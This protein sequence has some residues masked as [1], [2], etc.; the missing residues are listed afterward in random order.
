MDS[1]A[2]TILG[3]QFEPSYGENERATL[4]NEPKENRDFE[5]PQRI[6]EKNNLSSWCMCNNCRVMPTEEECTC[7][8]GIDEIKY[9]KLQGRC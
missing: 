1:E 9:F 2:T 4:V 8:T 7:C 5:E 6:K 3:F